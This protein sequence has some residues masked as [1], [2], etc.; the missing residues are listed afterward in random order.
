RNESGQVVAL[1]DRCPHR[2]VPLSMGSVV[3]GK[4]RCIYH[5]LEFD[6]TGVC[7]RN[8]HSSGNPRRLSTRRVPTITRHGMVWIWHG[9]EDRC[10]PA[11]IPDYDWLDSPG[12]TA[13]HGLMHVQADYRL[14]IDNLLDLSHAEYLHAKTVGTPGSSSSVETSVSV[15]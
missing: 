7:V 11:G 10:D 4:V 15:E 3:A 12:Y 6:S 2:G 14:V 1:I 8:P 9:D 5:A 13:I